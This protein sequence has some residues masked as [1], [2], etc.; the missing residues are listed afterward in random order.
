[1]L[2]QRGRATE[3][4]EDDD[5]EPHGV[6]RDSVAAAVRPRPGPAAPPPQAR[7]GRAR[8]RC[9]PGWPDPP[10]ARAPGAPA[11]TGPPPPTRRPA[12]S[13]SAWRCG[14]DRPPAG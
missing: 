6:T 9:P 2:R 7:R 13:S 14:W 10:T 3:N 5:R 8:R 12:H 1:L 11:R 4:E